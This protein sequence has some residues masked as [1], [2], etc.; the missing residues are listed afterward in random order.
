[1][2]IICSGMSKTGTKT[3][4]QA[5][6]ILGYEVY[7]FEEQFW[8]L[9]DRLIKCLDE[10]WTDDD[11]REMFKD[12]D[13]FTDI[14][15]CLLWEDISRVFP[16]AKIIHM[17][18]NNEDEWARSFKNQ[19]EKIYYN[20]ILRTLLLLSPTGTKLRRYYSACNR[21][22]AS[23]QALM[24]WKNIPINIPL[25]RMRYRMHNVNV[26]QSASVPKDRIHFLKHS[27]GWKPL[28]A[29][30]GV[31]E[32]DTPYPHRNKGGEIVQQLMDQSYV[33][34]QIKKEV[35]FSLSLIVAAL[36]FLVYFRHLLF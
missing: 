9:G 5:L 27:E 24:P 7:D 10:G 1:M 26:R 17:E 35:I 15:S 13:A 36:G 11:L 30:L 6:R 22:Q 4:C 34:V 16:D 20:R 2:K 28:C 19:L 29:F 33:F 21:V 31:S 23:C 14:P 8:Y 25:A 32:P 18:R 3:V 12:V